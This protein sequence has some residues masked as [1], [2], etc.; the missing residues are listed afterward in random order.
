MVTSRDMTRSH[1]EDDN[2]MEDDEMR[3]C[4]V[5][6]TESMPACGA[7]CRAV[8]VHPCMAVR[9]VCGTRARSCAS[10][11]AWQSCGHKSRQCHSTHVRGVYK[12]VLTHSSTRT[13][14]RGRYRSYVTSY[15]HFVY[16]LLGFLRVGRGN[17]AVAAAAQLLGDGGGLL[18]MWMEV[19]WWQG[20]GFGM[21]RVRIFQ[22]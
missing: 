13:T 22:L 4:S 10:I 2:K 17:A 18:G 11:H 7:P 16:N 21:R 15:N 5:H 3:K 1:D 12:A 6:R 8:C 14:G 9:C 20:A 19:G